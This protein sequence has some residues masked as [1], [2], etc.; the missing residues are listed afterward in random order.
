MMAHIPPHP[1]AQLAKVLPQAGLRHLPVLP[2]LPWSL[3]DQAGPAHLS[4]PE[5]ETRMEARTRG[6]TWEP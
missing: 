6:G 5:S 3:V 1:R 2:S 4:L